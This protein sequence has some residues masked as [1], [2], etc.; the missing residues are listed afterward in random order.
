[1]QKTILAVALASAFSMGTACSA[2]TNV[3]ILQGQGIDPLLEGKYQLGGDYTLDGMTES[4][5]YKA[6]IDLNGHNLTIT[7]DGSVENDKGT[8]S[9]DYAFQN[10]TIHGKG[11]LALTVTGKDQ[12]AFGVDSGSSLKADNIALTSKNGFCIWSEDNGTKLD[13]ATNDPTKGIIDIKSTNEAAIY[14]YGTETKINIT[15]FAVLN[16]ST[17]SVNNH[18][19]AINQNGG[20]L[21]IS[22]GKVYLSSD[23]HTA[24][25]SQAANAEHPSKTTFNVSELHVDAN[26]NLP[27]DES[28]I[29]RKTGAFTVS[30]SD[31]TVNADVFTVKVTESETNKKK[32][33]SALNI[34]DGQSASSDSDPVLTVNTKKTAI[35]GDVVAKAGTSTIKSETLQVTG[36]LTIQKKASMPL[37]FSGKDSFLTGQANIEKST[38][39]KGNNTLTFKENAVWTVKGESSVDALVV[40]NATV[41]ISATDKNVTVASLT[42]KNG[43]IVMDAAGENRLTATTN[44]V[45]ELK[46]VASKTADYV[47]TEEAAKMLDRI[48]A[49]GATIT[50]EVKEGDYNGSI[51]VDQQ[52]NTVTKTNTLMQDVLTL[53][54]ATTL[55]L[56]RILS[57]DIRKRMGDV[58][59]AEGTTGAWARWDGGRLS[60][61]AVENDF[62][63]IQVG[64]D[65]LVPNQNF[66]VG[67]AGSYTNG[68]ADFTRGSA[69]MDAWSLSAYG[70]WYGDNGMFADVIARVAKAETDVTAD[71]AAKKGTLENYAYSLSGEFGWRFNLSEQFYV[72]PQS[73]LTW[74]YIDEDDLHLGTAS[75][76]FDSMNSFMGRV[77]FATGMKCPNNKGDVYLRVSAVHEFAGDRKITGANG[78]TLEEDGKDTWVEY[79]IGANFNLT[80]NTYFWADVE[81]TEGATLDEDWRATIGVRH[82]F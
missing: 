82:A 36:D 23:K 3:K 80:P 35:T 28:G 53:N 33:I 54:G 81:R 42:G 15:D 64:V 66:R 17:T 75:Y 44:T 34:Y 27:E 48:N 57:N 56:N 19:N 71:G 61:G 46:A 47:T 14:V 55:S 63:T 37:T 49:K 2:D 1:M 43:T 70:L 29:E 74:T 18:G 76:T 59:S 4:I 9:G 39:D 8:Q 22:G 5:A 67:F 79:G 20:E 24:F 25:V 51:I 40:E 6:N 41:D 68:D 7:T 30:A 60:G 10:L 77:G 72:E 62:N 38:A 65:T 78:A 31:V 58:R 13:I 45:K 26:I 21:N 12:I 16:V 73:E 11:N 32:D 50:G 69:E 52:G